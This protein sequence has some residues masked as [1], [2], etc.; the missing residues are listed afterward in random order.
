MT[1]ILVAF[2]KHIFGDFH[3]Y[4][5]YFSP[6]LRENCETHIRPQKASRMG[7][8]FLSCCPICLYIFMGKRWESLYEP[9]CLK[10]KTTR[11]IVHL[12]IMR[13]RKRQT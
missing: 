6:M 13:E 12:Y 9:S 10:C 1:N 4:D 7:Q 3:G 2:I 11:E 5:P 8:T